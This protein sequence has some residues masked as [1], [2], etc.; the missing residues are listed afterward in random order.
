MFTH[1]FIYVHVYI[2]LEI[3]NQKRFDEM[4]KKEK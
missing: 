3:D 4:G 1:M 2:S